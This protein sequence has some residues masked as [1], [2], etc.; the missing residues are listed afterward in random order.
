MSDPGLLSNT[1]V[2][3]VRRRSRLLL[4]LDAAER[5]A[6]APLP[7]RRLHAFAYLADVLSPVWDLPPFDGKILKLEGGPHYADLQEELDHL[8]VIGL[9]EVFDLRYVGRGQNGAR[10][11]GNYALDFSSR[12]LRHLLAALGAEEGLT[13]IDEEDHRV[14]AFLVELAGA[15]AI[16]SDDQVDRAISQDV[17]YRSGPLGENIVDFAAWAKDP[18]KANPSWR[19]ADRFSTFLPEDSKIT[20]G[21]KIYLYAAYLGRV[22]NG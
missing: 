5:A 4:L 19:T 8:V 9:V 18:W 10:L 13:A 21:E 11:E 1:D 16:L 14:H 17:T 7:S 3:R 12:H 20:D 22:V 6:I 15:L 2:E